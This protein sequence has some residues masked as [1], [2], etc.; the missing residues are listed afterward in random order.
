MLIDVGSIN[1]F[2]VVLCLTPKA[3]Q[4]KAQDARL[5]GTLGNMSSITKKPNGLQ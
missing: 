1:A 4:K 5:L 3:S 2:F